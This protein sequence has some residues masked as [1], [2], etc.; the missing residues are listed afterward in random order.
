MTQETEDYIT[1]IEKVLDANLQEVDS[2]N[3]HGQLMITMVAMIQNVLKEIRELED[4][5]DL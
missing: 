1:E 2:T 3:T 4:E 5:V